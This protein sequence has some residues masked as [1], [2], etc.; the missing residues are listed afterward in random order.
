MLSSSSVLVSFWICRPPDDRVRLVLLLVQQY[1][2]LR[3]E[4]LHL[5]H[6]LLVQLHALPRGLL[7]KPRDP[8]P[9]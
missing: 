6:R 1:L 7:L 4:L 3:D 2:E 8:L 9:L 5:L